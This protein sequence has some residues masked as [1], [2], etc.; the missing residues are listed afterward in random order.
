MSERAITARDI[1][2]YVQHLCETEHSKAT[3]EKYLRAVNGFLAYLSGKEVTKE[4]M[5]GYKGHLT[6]HYSTSGVNGAL[7]AV[8]GL[9][10]FL[11][12][13]ELRVKALRQQKRIF[14]TP[15]RELSRGEYLRLLE[16]ARRKGQ[17][18]LMLVM[19]TICA[20]GIRVSELQFITVKAI[21][22]GR[23]EA[24]CKGKRR[25]IF[26]PRPLAK[27]LLAYA[28][29]RNIT[30]GVLFRTKG[31]RPLDRSNIWHDMK[32]L[33]SEAGIDR[34]KVF[35]HALRHLFARSYYALE[36]NL[37]RL[38]DLLG[39][40]SVE[41]TRIYTMESGAEHARQVARLGLVL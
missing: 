29:A 38:A 37:V 33:C 9:L 24:S 5:I 16:T 39:H 6:G 15:E 25:V 13:P 32:A 31:G 8:N 35:P 7:A 2:A 1:A 40:S 36:K 12:R 19:E 17:E 4:V 34:R 14:G 23:A 21:Q 18:R 26:I 27:K 41:T 22:T 11:G 20:T 10:T 28:R 3:V 30:R